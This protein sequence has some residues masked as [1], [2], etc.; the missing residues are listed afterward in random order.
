MKLHKEP[1]PESLNWIDFHVDP[2]I[3]KKVDIPEKLEDGE[4]MPEY[5]TIRI[6][7][8]YLR[9]KEINEMQ[10]DV[11]NINAELK[12]RRTG[13]VT[14]KFNYS[15]FM[16]KKM[17]IAIVEWENITDEEGNPVE[18]NMENIRLLPGWIGESL[19]EIIDEMNDLGP[20]ILGE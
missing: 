18:V 11:Y 6:C 14:S 15:L 8:R 4:E 17:E 12:G 20:E 19:I 10:D 13:K 2:V 16:E 9:I 1:L 3:G 7:L 5:E